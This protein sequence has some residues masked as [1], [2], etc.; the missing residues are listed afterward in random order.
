MTLEPGLLLCEGC[1]FAGTALEDK[2]DSL[3]T[4]R[5]PFYSLFCSFLNF[6]TV[7][8]HFHKMIINSITCFCKLKSPFALKSFDMYSELKHID[9]K[10]VGVKGSVRVST[11]HDA[12]RVKLWEP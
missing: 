6:I 5:L 12:E 1:R 2:N 7:F 9:R 4:F 8:F 11:Y 3:S 10:A